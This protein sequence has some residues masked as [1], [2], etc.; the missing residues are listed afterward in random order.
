MLIFQKAIV[1]WYIVILLST[2]FKQ[3]VKHNS[4]NQHRTI[5]VSRTYKL[6]VFV[7]Y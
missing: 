4:H 2:C 3:K 5:C 7:V 1:Y 6:T